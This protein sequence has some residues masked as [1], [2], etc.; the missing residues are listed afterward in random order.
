MRSFADTRAVECWGTLTNR[1]SQPLRNLSE[2]LTW[3]LDLP[4]QPAGPDEYAQVI[5][6]DGERSVTMEFN[7]DTPGSASL[8]M[9]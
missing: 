9:A 1:G 5:F 3:E 8:S 2:C 7:V 4:L 6:S